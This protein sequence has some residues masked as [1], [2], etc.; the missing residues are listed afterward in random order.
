MP[1]VCQCVSTEGGGTDMDDKQGPWRH[2]WRKQSFQHYVS[3]A[4][5][6][7]ETYLIGL[8]HKLKLYLSTTKWPTLK[9]ISDSVVT[10]CLPS[11]DQGRAY[12]MIGCAAWA[13]P[14]LVG[15]SVFRTTCWGTKNVS[16]AG[17]VPVSWRDGFQMERMH[18]L[19]IKVKDLL[20]PVSCE[21]PKVSLLYL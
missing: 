19:Y 10:L 3:K 2:V 17:N 6:G 8:I 9:K 11:A 15:G 18:A 12:A 16:L 13:H 5:I 20:S 4:E 7:G 1:A 21:I 14:L